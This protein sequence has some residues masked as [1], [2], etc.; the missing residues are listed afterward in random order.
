M[1]QQR[2]RLQELR[3]RQEPDRDARLELLRLAMQ[4][5]PGTDLRADLAAFNAAY[6]ADAPG[7]YTEALARLDKDEREGLALL[8]RAMEIDADAIKP[9]CER[10]YAYLCK[11]KETGLAEEYAERWRRQDALEGGR[12]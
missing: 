11:R 4:L 6:P 8:E 10:A 12:G 5:E 3:T 2:T 7:L 9:A 1:G